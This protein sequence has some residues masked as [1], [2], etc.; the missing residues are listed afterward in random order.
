[1]AS[2]ERERALGEIPTYDCTVQKK[3][4][5]SVA[6]CPSVNA[7]VKV[8]EGAWNFALTARVRFVLVRRGMTVIEENG[9]MNLAVTF[10]SMFPPVN[11]AVP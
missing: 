2:F 7:M 9:C 11:M 4:V 8:F 10:D 3:V 1:V 5:S 6:G